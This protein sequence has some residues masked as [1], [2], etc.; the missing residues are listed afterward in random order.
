[1]NV[2]QGCVDFLSEP[3]VV[4]RFWNH[5]VSSDVAT[6]PFQHAFLHV[7]EEDDGQ[8]GVRVTNDA[9]ERRA[10]ESWHIDIDEYQ[11][12][13]GVAN[14][15]ERSEWPPMKTS[16]ESQLREAMKSRDTV[17]IVVIDEENDGRG[18]EVFPLVARMRSTG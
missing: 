7:A 1:L 3:V 16:H 9:D 12:A 18:H 11:V 6:D 2:V 15:S 8:L 13:L 5:V 17:G 4:G 10:V 14:C